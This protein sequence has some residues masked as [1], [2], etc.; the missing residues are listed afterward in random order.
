MA[1]KTRIARIAR[2]SHAEGFLKSGHKY[3]IIIF[4]FIKNNYN[5]FREVGGHR[6][7]GDIH[8]LVK[9]KEEPACAHTTLA[10]IA[11]SIEV[12]AKKHKSE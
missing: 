4:V 8:K 7:S 5:S 2:L 11:T 9:F 1:L 3:I 6:V 12:E 10:Y